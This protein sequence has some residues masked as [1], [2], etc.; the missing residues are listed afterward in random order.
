MP[1]DM[2]FHHE[3]QSEFSLVLMPVGYWH[4]HFVFP[5]LNRFRFQ[6]ILPREIEEDHS[7]I[8]QWRRAMKKRAFQAAYKQ[9]ERIAWYRHHE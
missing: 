7:K 6:C 3:V 4:Y 1:R 5:H 9:I 8:E 2:R